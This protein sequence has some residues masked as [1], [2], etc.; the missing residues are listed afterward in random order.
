[1]NDNMPMPLYTV[2]VDSKNFYRIYEFDAD[3]DPPEGGWTTYAQAYDSL[4]AWVELRGLIKRIEAADAADGL[5][6]AAV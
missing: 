3:V 4:I 5:L 1:M 6:S 2:R